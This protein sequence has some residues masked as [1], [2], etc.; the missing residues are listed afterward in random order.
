MNEA[1]KTLD[2]KTVALL[3]ISVTDLE[4]VFRSQMIEDGKRCYSPEML[5]VSIA[6]FRFELSRD[7]DE[8]ADSLVQQV[9]SRNLESE[10]RKY[11]LQRG[12]QFFFLGFALCALE[13]GR[14]D[15]A[16]YAVDISTEGGILKNEEFLQKIKRHVEGF[17][18]EGKPWLSIELAKALNS[19]VVL[20]NHGKA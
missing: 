3:G 16:L 15:R 9:R 2:P 10:T 8:R 18:N 14:F 5:T 19:Y 12:Q 17:I 20:R 1:L 6:G 4:G 13:D 11:F 7:L